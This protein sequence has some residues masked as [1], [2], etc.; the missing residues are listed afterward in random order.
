V[1]LALR[2]FSAVSIVQVAGE[3]LPSRLTSPC[4]STA[5]RADAMAAPPAASAVRGCSACRCRHTT[6]CGASRRVSPAYPLA[7]P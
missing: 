2:T 5:R 6:R 7:K 1:G 4:A 3:N